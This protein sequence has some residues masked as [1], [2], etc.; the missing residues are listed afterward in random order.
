MEKA[1]PD[2]ALFAR[3]L[4][5]D[6]SD[7]ERQNLER[8]PE[9]PMFRR[10]ME[11]AQQQQ[12]SETDSQA[13]WS[14]FTA[15]NQASR[16]GTRQQTWL[17]WLMG[18]TALITLILMA[19]ALFL[20][21]SLA[22]SISA[23]TTGEQKT[24]ELP[25]G[26]TVRLNA[27]SSVEVYPRNWGS[28]RRVRLIGEA[29]FQVK[30]GLAP[31]V[32][33]TDAGSVSVLGTSFTVRY[34]GSGFEVACYSGF[35]QASTPNGNKQALR[36]SQKAVARNERWLHLGALADPWPSWMQGESRFGDA[37]VYEVFAELERQYNISISASGVDGRRFSGLFVHNDLP[38]AL[39]M[40]CEPLGLQYEIVDKQVLIRR[41]P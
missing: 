26:S 18:S 8:H 7:A 23:T 38:Q 28:E 11:S 37:P 9:F 6:I 16:P 17:W 24:V 30:K 22:P 4:R 14:R 5:G 31:F 34:R 25:D 1:F 20:P 12:L 2:N 19:W 15:G 3:W 13:L 29:F 35:V 21:G 10:L 33:E 27:V 40:V 32:V 36:A 39:R 41:K